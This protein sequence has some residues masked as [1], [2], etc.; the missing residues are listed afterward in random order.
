MILLQYA[1]DGILRIMRLS[2]ATH[3]PTDCCFSELALIRPNSAFW[4]S[5]KRTS[6]L[7]QRNVACFRTTIHALINVLIMYDRFHLYTN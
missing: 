2:E 1:Y 5:T 6:S 7:S 3:L 4:S